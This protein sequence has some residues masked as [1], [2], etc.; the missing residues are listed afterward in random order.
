MIDEPTEDDVKDFKRAFTARFSNNHGVEVEETVQEDANNLAQGITE[1]LLD[2]YGRAQHLLW[3]SH[4][5]D[6]PTIG[7]E[8]LK[9]I[10]RIVVNGVIKAF[11]RGI[12]DENIKKTILMRAEKLPC[13]FFKTYQ[14]TQQKMRGLEQLKEFENREYEK[15]EI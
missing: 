11:I 5:G 12:K 6:T 10:E 3:R 4:A 2:Y 13:S 1:S 14:I 7:G 9:P 15:M 8:E